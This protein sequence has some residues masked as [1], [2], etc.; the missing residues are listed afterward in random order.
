[1]QDARLLSSHD[2]LLMTLADLA[3]KNSTA[4]STQTEL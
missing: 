3:S 4:Q 2:V 1:M